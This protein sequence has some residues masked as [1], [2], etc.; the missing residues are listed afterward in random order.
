MFFIS[1]HAL[2]KE[3]DITA[4]VNVF[5]SSISIH[6]LRKECDVTNEFILQQPKLFLSTHSVR[7]AT[8]KQS[9]REQIKAEFLS[10]HSVRSATGEAIDIVYKYA[11]FYPRTP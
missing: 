7:S 11:N 10:T 5:S 1:I 9:Y 6:A 8:F 4:A 3:C 2:R